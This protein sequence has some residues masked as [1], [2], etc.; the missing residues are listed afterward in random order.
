[1]QRH[2]GYNLVH[3]VVE[4]H[5]PYSWPTINSMME[6]AVQVDLEFIPEDIAQFLGDTK[7]PGKKAASWGRTL[8]ASLSMLGNFLVSYRAD[9]RTRTYRQPED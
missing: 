4:P 6:N 3:N 2:A 9:G 5:V 1:M 8:A 7:K